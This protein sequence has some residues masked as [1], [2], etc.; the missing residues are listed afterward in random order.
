MEEAE[1]IAKEEHGSYKLAVIA[2]EWTD[3]P[4][5]GLLLRGCRWLTLPWECLGCLGQALALGTT[6]DDLGT[7]RMDRTCPRYFDSCNCRTCSA[8]MCTM[9]N[10][11]GLLII[12]IP[13]DD[14]RVAV[15]FYHLTNSTLNCDLA[16]SK[17][18]RPS[19]LPSSPSPPSTSTTVAS[20]RSVPQRR[21]SRSSHRSVNC[22]LRSFFPVFQRI[23]HSIPSQQVHFC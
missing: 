10:R 5:W 15:F 19:F 1:R 6:T 22:R 16:R 20:F 21:L 4:V 17:T 23:G 3:R 7:S 2:G 12:L 8:G 18:P 9:F 14:F 13:T 11:R